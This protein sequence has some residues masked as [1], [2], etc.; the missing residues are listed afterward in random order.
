MT[1]LSICETCK[2]LFTVREMRKH[3]KNC[4]IKAARE[5][6]IRAEQHQTSA[7]YLRAGS[8]AAPVNQATEGTPS[9]VTDRTNETTSETNAP[10][11]VWDPLYDDDLYEDDAFM[12]ND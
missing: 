12:E 5:A 10:D 1:K 2:N 11:E 9:N 4:R 7:S 3:T 6:R 8:V